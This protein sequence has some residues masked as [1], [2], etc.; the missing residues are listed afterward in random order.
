MQ[1]R[2][3]CKS[4]T[5]LWKVRF[6]I[7]HLGLTSL[8]LR[9]QPSILAKISKFV[10]VALPTIQLSGLVIQRKTLFQWHLE[11]RAQKSNHLPTQT[12]S[13]I[14]TRAITGIKV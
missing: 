2:A 11:I 7:W 5:W 12:E 8:A 6:W 14:S 4:I 13:D 1:C 9:W 3:P 10:R